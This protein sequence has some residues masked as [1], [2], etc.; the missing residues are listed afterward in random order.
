[1]VWL[2]YLNLVHLFKD[3]GLEVTLEDEVS[4][5]PRE[6][7]ANCFILFP[8]F[9]HCKQL[10]HLQLQKVHQQ[11]SSPAIITVTLCHRLEEVQEVMVVVCTTKPGCVVYVGIDWEG[12]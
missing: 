12:A 7:T 10:W 3:S 9:F 6:L 4:K 2:P 11:V 5:K 8:L 1:M